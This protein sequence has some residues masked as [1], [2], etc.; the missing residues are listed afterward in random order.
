MNR[1]EIRIKPQDS[2]FKQMG[3][4]SVDIKEIIFSEEIRK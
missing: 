1:N 3:I 4:N 2:I